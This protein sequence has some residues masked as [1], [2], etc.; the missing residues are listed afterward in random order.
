[1]HANNRRLPL[2]VPE[3]D[4]EN[5]E[6]PHLFNIQDEMKMTKKWSHPD[7][8]NGNYSES[9]VSDSLALLEQLIG[10]LFCTP[11]RA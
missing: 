3:H 8:S 4:N 9:A 7:E 5:P 1:M 10:A 6:Y 2:F 11:E